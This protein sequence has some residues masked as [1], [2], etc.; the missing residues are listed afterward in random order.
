MDSGFH[1]HCASGQ[2]SRNYGRR[3]WSTPLISILIMMAPDWGICNWIFMNG[4]GKRDMVFGATAVADSGPDQTASVISRVGDFFWFIFFVFE[5]LFPPPSHILFGAKF[6]CRWSKANALKN[7]KLNLPLRRLPQQVLFN[8][9]HVLVLSCF[10]PVPA[11]FA[12]KIG[13]NNFITLVGGISWFFVS[14]FLLVWKTH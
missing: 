1:I 7:A 14:P 3:S 10:W 6:D 13:L 4:H 2:H 9:Q 12:M 11:S 5:R 8:E